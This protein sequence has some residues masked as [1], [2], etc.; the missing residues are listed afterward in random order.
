MITG[1]TIVIYQESTQIA[2]IRSNSIGNECDLMEKASPSSGRWREFE[3]GRVGWSVQVGRLLALASDIK[4]VLQVG[5]SYTI[6]VK[7]QDGTSL[8]TGTAI[9]KSARIDSNIENLCTGSF[10]FQGT[11]P[12]TDPS[13]T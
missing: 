1:R 7:T 6:A 8:L 10:V 4:N 12:L 9:C 13:V 11:G 5:Q 2:A 3:A